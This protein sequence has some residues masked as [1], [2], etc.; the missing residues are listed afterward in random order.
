MWQLTK[1]F[2]KKTKAEKQSAKK[3]IV[4]LRDHFFR[5]VKK[6]RDFDVDILQEKENAVFTMFSAPRI[7]VLSFLHTAPNHTRFVNATK[8]MLRSR[9][10]MR[11]ISREILGAG[12]YVERKEKI[13]TQTGRDKQETEVIVHSVPIYLYCP[14]CNRLTSQGALYYPLYSKRGG[15]YKTEIEI[16]KDC[17]V[18][19]CKNQECLSKRS[20]FKTL[21]TKL[22]EI[23]KMEF[24]YLFDPY[25]DFFAPFKADAHIFG[26]DYGDSFIHVRSGKKSTPPV[27]K[28]AKIFEILEQATGEKEKTIYVG[29]MITR[30]GQKLSKSDPNVTFRIRDLKKIKKIFANIIKQIEALREVEIEDDILRIEYE[31]IIRNAV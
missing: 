19:H 24:H 15:P 21:V 18:S 28:V 11:Q 5:E 17:L 8:K 4:F 14:D 7:R 26:G 6:V 16:I 1:V 20:R 2:D 27:Q 9:Q 13:E 22:H 23:D 29:G 3:R 12:S 25:R 30:D 31:K 10:L